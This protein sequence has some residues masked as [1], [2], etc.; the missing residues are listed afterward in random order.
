[1][2]SYTFYENLVMFDEHT[3]GM[4]RP[5]ELA[6]DWDWSDKS[7]C[8]YK[9]AGLADAVLSESTGR[10]AQLVNVEDGGA[11][12]S[13]FN[14]LSFQ[15]SDVVRVPRLDDEG[16]FDLIDQETGK[17]VPHQVV[18]L[19]DPLAP[20]PYAA[21]RY[22][23]GQRSN[24]LLE[25]VFVAEDVPPLGYKTYRLAPRKK[26][27]AFGSSLEVGATRLEN[28]FFRIE[29]DARSGAI[30]SLYDKQLKREMVDKDAPHKLN[31]FIIKDAR[32]GKELRN[33]KATIRKGQSGPVYASLLVSGAGAGCPQLTQEIILYDHVKRIDVANRFLKDTT[34]FLQLY[35][36]FP[37][38]VD[39]PDVRFE[40]P[41]SV[42]EPL[43]D[44][45][46]GSNTHYYAVQHWA[47][48]SDGDF[49][50][51]LAPVESHLLMFG[52]L[53]PFHVAQVHHTVTP[54]D[55]TR[56]ML[57][58]GELTKGR[59]Y[60]YVLN[61]N[62]HTN[63]SAVQT[64]DLLFRYSITT[65]TG[66]WTA[67]KPR[68]FGWATGN[69]LVPVLVKGD[70][71][72]DSAGVLP[73]SSSFASVDKPNVLLLTLKRAEDGNGVI[74][75]LVET[76]GAACTVK[77]TLPLLTIGDACRTNLVEEDEQI[78]PCAKHSVTVPM[79]AGGITTVRVLEAVRRKTMW[80]D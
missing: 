61:N 53:W 55:F 71:S 66:D 57:K 36:A 50:V 67:G 77:V 6:Q 35:F 21:H 75:R 24:E 65:H 18:E 39:R 23:M 34:P 13:V 27:R 8:A 46:P 74:V 32:T 2:F 30:E 52:D 45:F 42:I 48:V 54:P 73:T 14:A 79:K 78:L 12:V 62:F 19:D 5:I 72:S 28:R 17:R 9:A 26:A 44:Q 4:D 7:R 43:V 58:P 60:S 69:P 29:L 56:P 80:P 33:K 70:G 15:R 51:T 68:D 22:A 20:A 76:E 1:M 31:Q 59:I 10:I 40:G 49:G 64:G 47:D 63:F 25:L 37:F 16:D 41:N 38:K 11:Y 3:W